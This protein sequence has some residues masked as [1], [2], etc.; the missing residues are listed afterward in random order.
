[1][2][3]VRS[4]QDLLLYLRKHAA[5]IFVRVKIEGH[6]QNASLADLSDELWAEHVTGFIVAWFTGGF[7]PAPEQAAS[8]GESFEAGAWR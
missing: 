5:H 4:L 2:A 3:E 1:V 7:V 6:W 8:E